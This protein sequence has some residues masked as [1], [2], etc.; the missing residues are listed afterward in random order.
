MQ[1]NGPLSYKT[2]TSSSA[3]FLGYSSNSVLYEK[4]S[5]NWL[6]KINNQKNI[7]ISKRKL[8]ETLM[9][10]PKTGHLIIYY[11]TLFAF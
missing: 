7:L 2:L 11:F 9:L 5:M 6:L 1:N 4:N 3:R 10:A 8:Q